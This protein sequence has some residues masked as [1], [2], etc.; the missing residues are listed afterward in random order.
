MSNPKAD[1]VLY[2]Y[3]DVAPHAVSLVLTWD[4]N[5]LQK[6][7]YYVS[8]SLHEAKVRYL[9]LEKAILAV[10]HAM[11]KLPH[12]FQ[13][14]TVVVLAQLP[15]KPTLRSADYNGRIALW[16]IILGAF[17]IKYMPRTSIKVQ[18]LAN[19]VAEFA[20]PLVEI[21]AEER[22]T[23]GKF[24]RVVSV[25]G[26]LC[27][28]VYV[29]GA[30][31]QRGSGVGLVLVSFEETIIEK[32]LRLG[33]LA[34]N[35]EA[36]YE[37][38]LQQMA[39][40]QKMGGKTIEMFSDS[41]LVVGQV[42]GELEAKD[43]RMQRSGNTHANSLAALATFLAGGLPWT[44]IVEHLDRANEVA[45]GVDGHV[46]PEDG[47]YGPFLKAA[48]NKR[49]LLVGTDYFTK[50]VKTKPLVNI[51]DVDAKKFIWRNIVT[52]F[53]VPHTLISNNGLQ[54]DSKT[55]KRYCYKLR[56]TNR[57]STPTYPQRN[58]QAE[59]VNKV[60]VN[61]LKK[62]LD[63]AKRKWVEELP[64]VLWTYRTTPQCSTGET[65]FAMT[66]G[67]KVV[68]PLEASFPTLR[69]S[70]FTLSSNDELLG[71]SLDLI[72]EQRERVVI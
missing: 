1:E 52:R 69:M 66:Y 13:T 47:P 35:N 28:K 51:R 19:L 70:S 32:S 42:K 33:F 58:R 5:G 31:N 60:I 38:L 61:G 45:K 44:I 68:I 46:L 50:W 20:E 39:I 62:R 7:V 11:R 25:P 22:N 59:A 16:N 21:V 30:A 72:D 67:A 2:A 4:D 54:F 8:K 15:L 64:H 53:G 36:G 9:L 14:H 17:D 56:I 48:R 55:F 63:D 24:V 65:P 23:D 34:T 49:Y 37:A 6:P 27:W 29:D 71:K 26:P 12:Y 41:R 3:I 18:V 10:V 57:Y 43:A 40:M